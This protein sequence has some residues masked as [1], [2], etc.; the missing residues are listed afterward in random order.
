VTWSAASPSGTSS[1]RTSLD[2]DLNGNHTNHGVRVVKK[3]KG[4]GNQG[5]LCSHEPGQA[6]A[7]ES[8]HAQESHNHVG[9]AQPSRH[10]AKYFAFHQPRSKSF[11][12]RRP[13]SKI[14][15]IWLPLD[16]N[17]CIST[18]LIQNLLY[19]DAPGPNS[20]PLISFPA[21]GSYSTPAV[22][23]HSSREV[24]AVLCSRRARKLMELRRAR[25]LQG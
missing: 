12:F 23:L 5:Q 21:V 1:S 13:R 19:S 18:F 17:L 4:I 3:F 8:A 11:A 14:F 2:G 20:L 6:Q 16:Q 15:C 24:R 10:N 9:N 7:Q 25:S 22:S